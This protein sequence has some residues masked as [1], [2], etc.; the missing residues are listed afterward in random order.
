MIQKSKKGELHKLFPTCVLEVQ[1]FLTQQECKDVLQKVKEDKKNLKKHNSL[2]GNAAT[3]YL[4]Q[5]FLSKLNSAI[6][7]SLL[8]VGKKYSEIIGFEIQNTFDGSWFNIQNKNSSLKKHNHPMSTISG[9]IYI[10]C[11]KD[12]FNTYF[13]N[14]NPMLNFTKINKDT[15]SSVDWVAFKPKI[16][17]LLLFPSWL[18]HGSN[19]TKN[20]SKERIV[21]SFN[22]I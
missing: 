17:T 20:K 19:F 3:T 15:E 14:P 7:S 1:D 4:E 10:Q 11:D 2:L 13:H 18:Q 6:Q 21:I 22:I 8:E 9:I 12:S 5:N 16:G